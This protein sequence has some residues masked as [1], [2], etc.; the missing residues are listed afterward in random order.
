MSR[1]KA[2]TVSFCLCV[3]SVQVSRSVVPDSATPWIAA[4]QA[5]LSITSSRSLLKLMSVESVMPSNRLILRHPVLLSSVFPSIRIF[6][7]ESVFHIRWP[8][9]WSFSFS[10]S[11]SCE[12]SGLIAFRM[13][14]FDLEVQGTLKR[15]LQHHSLKASVL[16]GSAFFIGQ[17]SYPHM[18]TGKTIALTR[19]T[20]VGKVMSLLFN[21]LSRLVITFLPRGR[22][23]LISWLQSPTAM[24]L[25]LKKIK[26]SHSF[27]C[28]TVC[29]EV[30][31]LEAMIFVF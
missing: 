6:S 17:H 29:H 4:L 20:F 13:D 2:G 23:L 1:S 12:F 14:W 5:S 21:M 15:L 25:E 10:V 11:P 22:C 31:G 7:N 19:W 18:T 28:F 16:L 26:V 3:F 9:Y 24:I 30:I 8:N 27:R